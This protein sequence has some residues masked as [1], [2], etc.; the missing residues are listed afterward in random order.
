GTDTGGSIRIPSSF[1]GIAGLKPT[2]GRVS[3]YG[4]YPLGFSLDH[5]GPMARNVVDVGL[6]HQIISGF[7]PKDEFSVDQEI[8]EIGLRK[9][10]AG[11][12]IG[13]PTNFFFD[14]LQPEVE[15]LV[16]KAALVLEELGAAVVP[17]AIPGMAELTEASAASL[18]AEA[19]VL[20]KDHLEK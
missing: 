9:S 14:A 10:L 1:C 16:R 13:V 17:V 12:R 4:V 7:D 8:C 3:L 2:R 18:T 19:Y 5:G 11:K 6:I 20:H 15:H